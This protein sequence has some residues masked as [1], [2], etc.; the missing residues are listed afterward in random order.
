MLYEEHFRYNSTISEHNEKRNIANVNKNF[1]I[2]NN[3]VL[4]YLR[5]K[6]VHCL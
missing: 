2:P 6:K 1:I 5:A 3:H 4:F